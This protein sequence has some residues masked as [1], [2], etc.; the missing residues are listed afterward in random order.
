[1]SAATI[2]CPAVSATALRVRVPAAGS[3]SMR[4]ALIVSRASTSAKPKLATV[5]TWATSSLVVTVV[6]VPTGA[7]FTGVTLIVTESVSLCAP[8]LPLPPWSLVAIVIP[9][10]PVKFRVGRKLMPARA[11]FT[12]AIVP[13]KVMLASAVPS[14][15]LK[16]KPAVPPRVSVPFV[17]ARLIRA[18]PAPRS[19]SPI[20]KAS[21]PA[22]TSA[23]SSG[24]LCAP[25]TELTGAS[26]TPSTLVSAMSAGSRPL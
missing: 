5:K 9:A 3:V 13:V 1:M 16:L 17:P 15:T 4:T 14:P 25:G 7:L 26:F 8:P 18:R 20:E 22:N 19:G 23:V 24:V 2:T 11:V 21:G 12:A 6:S 10:A